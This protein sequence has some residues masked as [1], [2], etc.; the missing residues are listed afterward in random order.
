MMKTNALTTLIVL[1]SVLL[2]FS[3]AQSEQC[4]NE[5]SAILNE[6]ITD[7]DPLMS[8]YD[9]AIKGNFDCTVDASEFADEFE[10]ACEDKG[11]KTFVGNV[12]VT[13]AASNITQ[14]KPITWN[15]RTTMHAWVRAVPKR[16]CRRLWKRRRKKLISKSQLLDLNVK[17]TL[18]LIWMEPH[19][20]DLQPLR[21]RMGQP[22]P[23][24]PLR[25]R[26]PTRM[27]SPPIVYFY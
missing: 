6:T 26:R 19:L 1:F 11:G 4:R 5:T 14:G 23:R 2:G 18:T 8:C 21:I 13:C 22:M 3:N 9:E 20:R 7:S 15:V 12:E 25:L 24:V 16:I 10:Q 17:S 27:L